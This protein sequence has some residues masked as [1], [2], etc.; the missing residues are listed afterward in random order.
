[1]SL[2]VAGHVATAAA[3]AYIPREFMRAYRASGRGGL[4][5]NARVFLINFA[6]FILFCGGGHLLTVALLWQGNW[7][8]WA[9][10]IWTTC[11]TAVFSWIAAKHVGNRMQ[12]IVPLLQEP[13]LWNE[14]EAKL[15]EAYG[16][17]QS[18]RERL[19]EV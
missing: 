2:I 4:D 1:M 7:L 16:E 15:N 19:G 17:I 10:A 5:R 12:Y 14:L 18:L 3:Y 6:L 8:Y 9:E 13:V 11:G